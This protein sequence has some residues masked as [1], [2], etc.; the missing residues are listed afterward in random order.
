MKL[1]KIKRTD[2]FLIF[3]YFNIFCKG[4]GLANDSLFYKSLIIIVIVALLYK[5]MG[6]GYTKKE[7]L[8][9]IIIIFIGGGTFLKTGKP[10]LFLT[11]MCIVGMKNIDIDK[12]FHSMLII[13]G[14]TF[15]ALVIL[16]LSGIIENQSIQMWRSGGMD[17]RYALGFSHPNSLHL[18]LFILVNL[19]IY[20][21]YKRINILDYLFLSAVNLFIYQ[22]SLSRTGVV[23]VFLQLIFLLISKIK[24]NIIK[25]M[26]IKSCKYI[27]GFM[28]LTSFICAYL[29]GKSS[30]VTGL[31]VLFNGRLK[32]SNYYITNYGFT[33]L[34]NN[35]IGDANALFDNGYLYL[36]I[37]FGLLGVI[38]ISRLIFLACKYTEKTNDLCKAIII[39]GYLIYIFTESFSPNIFMN[40][41]LFFAIPVIYTI[42]NSK[43]IKY[44]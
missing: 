17:T 35:I 29:Y 5:V 22:Y 26:M 4:I 33:L 19:Y 41:M 38:L 43:V 12:L 23:V 34:G 37:Q 28:F 15:V 32:F 25:S 21:R 1:Y 36:Y 10:T 2:F 20:V 8:F 3:V 42:K 16:A 13:R 27:F 30:F 7:L 24:I 9:M 31:D 14:T 6:E 40:N 11:C 44:G 18:S 39:N